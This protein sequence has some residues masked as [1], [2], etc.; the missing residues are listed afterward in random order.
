MAG[1]GGEPSVFNPIPFQPSFNTSSVT[2]MYDGL[3]F[4][5]RCLDSEEED[6]PSF[7]LDYSRLRDPE[8]MLQFL[9]VCNEMLSERSEGY[10][11][12]GEGYD[13]T[14]EFFHIDSEIP[15]EGDHLGMPR[16]D[17]QPPP[18]NPDGAQTPPGSH[19]AHLEQL[20]EL[21]NKLG[22]E[23]Q[24]LQQLLQALEGEAAGKALDGGTRAKARDVQCCIK[25]DVDAAE[26]SILNRASQCLAVAPF[27]L[28]TMP[29][30]STIEGRCIHDE[31]WGLLECVAVQQA[32]RPPRA[33]SQG[34]LVSRGKPQCILWC[35]IVFETTASSRQFMIFS[36]DA[37]N[38]ARHSATVLGGAGTTAARRTEVL[39]PSR[40]VPRSSARP[41]A[42]HHS[43]LGSE[44]QLLSPITRGIRSCSSGLMTIGSPIS[45]EDER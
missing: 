32:E 21:H 38:N 27:L 28:R 13:P 15:E 25:E 19:V 12:G 22:E 18:H 17:D 44:P 20:R 34:P 45:S 29:E 1:V 5:S 40:Q 30:P 6:G 16:E 7:A 10:N 4:P 3:P 2:R 39:S 42:E 24:C 26:P 9:Y 35:T 14:R 36:V 23:Q 41:S 37:P 31:L 11:S 33:I 8:S 43:H